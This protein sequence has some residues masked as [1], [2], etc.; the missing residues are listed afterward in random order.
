ME[1]YNKV[2]EEDMEKKVMELLTRLQ[3]N[4]VDPFGFGLRYRATRLSDKGIM[5][6]WKRIYPEIEFNVTMNIELKSP[7]AVE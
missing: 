5:K 7:G 2:A 4:D 1:K 6:E 3:E